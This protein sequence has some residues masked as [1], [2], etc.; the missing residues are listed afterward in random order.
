MSRAAQVRTA[1]KVIDL[2]AEFAAAVTLLS[3]LIAE[4]A[5]P[6][7]IGEFGVWPVEVVAGLYQPLEPGGGD[8]SVILPSRHGNELIDLVAYDMADPGKWWLRTGVGEWI[9]ADHVEECDFK[10]LPVRLH[11]TPQGWLAAGGTGACVLTTRS[12]GAHAQ[13]MRAKGIVCDDDAHA[14]R[15]HGWLRRRE[16]PTY[17]KV[18]YIRAE[19]GPA[20]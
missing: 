19:Q 16:R 4:S 10:E 20:S 2:E 9:G 15:V 1:E 3:T 14:A 8:L 18:G 17:P 6:K 5:R 12:F 11:G 13:L 7:L